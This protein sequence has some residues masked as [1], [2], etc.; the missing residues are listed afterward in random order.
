MQLDRLDHSILILLQ[1]NCR[2]STEEMGSQV[3]LSA[4]ACQRRIKKL[5]ETGVIRKEV[6]ILDGIQSGGFVTVIVEVIIHQG[7]ESEIDEIKQEMLK[8]PEVQQCYYVTGGVDFILIITAEN[9]LEYEKL[10]RK[11]FFNNRNI[12]KFHSTVAMENV[13]VGLEIPLK[14]DPY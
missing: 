13:K 8:H 2:I 3:G 4:T 10:T 12:Q 7:G 6:A 9:M 5:R 11:L 1:K 14:L